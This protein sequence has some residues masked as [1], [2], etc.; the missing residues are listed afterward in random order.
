MKVGGVMDTQECYA[1][2]QRDLVRL[3]MWADKNFFAQE[4]QSPAPA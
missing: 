1:S 3:E 2:I 4:M